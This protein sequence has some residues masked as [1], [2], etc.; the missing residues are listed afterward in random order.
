VSARAAS[1]ALFVS[2]IWRSRSTPS[3]AGDDQHEVARRRRKQE[4][5]D[6]QRDHDRLRKAALHCPPPGRRTSAT[7][8]K[9]TACAGADLRQRALLELDV[10]QVGHDREPAQQPRD[11]RMRVRESVDA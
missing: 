3:R 9:C 2:A 1:I 6:D 4:A 5:D 11:R 8:T 7:I 10:D